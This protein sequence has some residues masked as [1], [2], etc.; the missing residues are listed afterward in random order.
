[1]KRFQH[2][3]VDLPLDGGDEKVL[4]W[5]EHL[6]EL[7]GAA[8]ITVLHAWEAEE[9]PASVKAK[10]PW[11]V[12]PGEELLK[13]RASKEVAET[14]SPAWRERVEV[15]LLNE[16]RLPGVLRVARDAEVDLIVTMKA[17]ATGDP[18]DFATRLARKAPCS[19]FFVHAD[20]PVSYSSVLVPVDY[21]EH[22]VGALD[23]GCAAARARGLKEVRVLRCFSIPYGQHRAAVSEKDLRAD[24][25]AIEGERMDKFLAEHAPDDVAVKGEIVEV[26]DTAVGIAAYARKQGMDLTVMGSRGKHAVSA[27]FLGSTAESILRGVGTSVLMIK[28][29]GTG[30]GFLESL[31]GK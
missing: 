10:Y 29:K 13:E 22:S 2:I 4:K 24:Y 7:A 16:A 30:L 23:F 26:G 25:E 8:R 11:L 14:M 1:M 12:A 27:L 15:K 18:S 9:I 20:G 17:G 28:P 19:V 21:S 6:A 3:L 5:A 31:L